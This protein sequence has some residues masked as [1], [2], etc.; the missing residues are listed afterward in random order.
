[1][2]TIMTTKALFG[3]DQFLRGDIWNKFLHIS[4]AQT[5][6][7]WPQE[8]RVS[9]GLYILRTRM[10]ASRGRTTSLHSQHAVQ[11]VEKTQALFSLWG[12]KTLKQYSQ[13]IQDASVISFHDSG[14]V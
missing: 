13:N 6:I 7:K 10:S 3:L 8:E 14:S 9:S 12:E 5:A 2:V 4:S 11:S 1:M